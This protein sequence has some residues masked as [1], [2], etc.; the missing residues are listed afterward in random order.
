[1]EAKTLISWREMICC[2]LSDLNEKLSF[3]HS[4]MNIY[5]MEATRTEN[6]GRASEQ[7]KTALKRS[8]TNTKGVCVPLGM[9]KTEEYIFQIQIGLFDHQSLP[10]Y[11]VLSNQMQTLWNTIYGELQGKWFA[12]LPPDKAELFEKD[13]LF[14]DKV[15]ISFPTADLDI[16]A[17]GTCLAADLNTAAVYHLM[18]AVEIGLRALAKQLKVKTVKKTVPIELGTWE[19]VISALELKVASNFPR[20][21]KGQIESDFYKAIFIEF[22][23]IKD[24]WRN[25]VMHARRL[26]RCVRSVGP[27]F[28]SEGN[29]LP[30]PSTTP[31]PIV[32]NNKR[33]IAP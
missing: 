1:M 4:H 24:L 3:I 14:G 18:C 5:Q 15:S 23:A 30:N 9:A 21:K 31:V 26:V 29:T 20:T 6:T 28:K 22:R 16:K 8:L 11:S 17:A 10:L 2:I 27:T 25:K 33:R 32:P 12:Y 7:Q 13:N 19:N